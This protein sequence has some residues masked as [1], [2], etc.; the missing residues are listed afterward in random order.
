MSFDCIAVAGG[1]RDRKCGTVQYF[2]SKKLQR[3]FYFID[4]FILWIF[5]TVWT[6]WNVDGGRVVCDNN[7]N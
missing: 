1:R 2:S 7:N 5:L 4:F 3:T 6:G